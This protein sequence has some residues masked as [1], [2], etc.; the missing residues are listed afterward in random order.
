MNTKPIPIIVTLMAAGVSC[1]ISV[2][3]GVD[4][5]TFLVRLICVIIIFYIVGIAVGIILLQSFSPSATKPKDGESD[6]VD[7]VSKDEKAQEDDGKA[8]SNDDGADGEL[9]S[10]ESSADGETA[11]AS[12][13]SL[14]E[15]GEDPDKEDVQDSLGDNVGEEGNAAE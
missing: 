6:K 4:F 8:S 5:T 13:E 15:E 11:A 9:N 1:V 12:D 7:P 3:Q 10:I 14:D 2:I